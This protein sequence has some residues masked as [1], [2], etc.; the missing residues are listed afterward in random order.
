MFGCLNIVFYK[1]FFYFLKNN[2]S[3][4]SFLK[5]VRKMQANYLAEALFEKAQAEFS[6]KNYPETIDLLKNALGQMTN[7]SAKLIGRI[8]LLLAKSYY[9][10]A[11][12]RE[13]RRTCEKSRKYFLTTE[14]VSEAAESY[15][16]IGRIYCEQ[17]R[18]TDA[19]VEYTKAL[20]LLPG[21]YLPAFEL[22]LKAE[23]HL[24]LG[25]AAEEIKATGLEQKHYSQSLFISKRLNDEK[26]YAR[27]LLGLGNYFFQKQKISKAHQILLK[28]IQHFNRLGMVRE[29]ALAL[30]TLGQVYTK[31]FE[32]RRA[33][34]AFKFAYNLFEQMED[35]LHEASS[36]VF[37]GRIFAKIDI[38]TTEKICQNV[39]DL[40]IAHTSIH[41]KRQA[42]IIFGRYSIVM[43]LIYEQNS[44]V[45][46]ARDSIKAGM[47]VFKL[48]NCPEEYLE[49]LEIFKNLKTPELTNRPRKN[50][51]NILSFKL[52][53]SS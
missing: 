16:L 28:S 6:N 14:L 3:I 43:G 38:E 23:I 11:Q 42:E 15:C 26:L 35:L 5:G 27:S 50:K 25:A 31:S 36:L 21:R 7:E 24:A 22:A 53:L 18:Y 2:V 30:H 12:Y 39:T 52:G 48:H 51:N 1:G 33:V 20:E 10:T 41:S 32:Y 45:E 47:D 8:H 34:N 29:V 17:G 9:A 19:I 44:M 49:A 13:A 40:L 4:S 46:M 37:L